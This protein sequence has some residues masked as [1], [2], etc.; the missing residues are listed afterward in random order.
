MIIIH[1]HVDVGSPRNTRREYLHPG[2]SMPKAGEIP[3]KSRFSLRRLAVDGV[4]MIRH[5]QRHIDMLRTAM[6]AMF[7]LL[8]F[9]FD[10]LI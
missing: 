3:G 8:R 1:V 2:L 10:Y 7:Y 4:N 6:F 5:I 9:A